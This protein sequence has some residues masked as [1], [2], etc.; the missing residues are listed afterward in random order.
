MYIL[1]YSKLS[2]FKRARPYLCNPELI[3]DDSLNVPLY[4]LYHL[5]KDLNNRTRFIRFGLS[6]DNG[7]VVSASV[8][9]CPSPLLRRTG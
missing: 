6:D 2:F 8:F 1:L 3:N 9:T 5:E 4:H 7:R